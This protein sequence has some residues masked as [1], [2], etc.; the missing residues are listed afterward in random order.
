MS[1]VDQVHIVCSPLS[2]G[3]F[4]VERTV[5]SQ[6]TLGARLFQSLNTSLSIGWTIRMGEDFPMTIRSNL[7]TWRTTLNII[8]EPDR[9]STRG[10]LEY[11]DE[12]HDGVTT[13]VWRPTPG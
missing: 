13:V 11:T 7:E 8:T 10:R 12:K 6:G 3:H 5:I 4:L 2:H 1:S 9:S